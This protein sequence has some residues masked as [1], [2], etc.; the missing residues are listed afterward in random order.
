MSS[1]IT[2]SSSEKSELT[3]ISR[4]TWII[5]P[6]RGRARLGPGCATE[7][8]MDYHDYLRE[9]AAKYRRLAEEASDDFIKKELLDLA[10]VCEE[11]ADTIEDRLTGG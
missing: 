1:V 10:L 11:V 8:R 5:L 3:G 2:L 6:S 7:H 9:E 4:L